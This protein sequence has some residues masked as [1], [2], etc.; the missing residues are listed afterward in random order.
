MEYHS[1]KSLCEVLS[2]RKWADETS[3]KKNTQ[4]GGE[5]NSLFFQLFSFVRNEAMKLWVLKML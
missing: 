5:K 4:L 2:W 3:S 1:S